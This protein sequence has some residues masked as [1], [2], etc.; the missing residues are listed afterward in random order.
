L[1]ID[2]GEFL[3]NFSPY[4]RLAKKSMAGGREG[5]VLRKISGER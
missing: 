5:E 1:K 3:L 4:R 2:L